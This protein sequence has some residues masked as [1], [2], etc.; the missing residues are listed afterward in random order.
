[1][2]LEGPRLNKQLFVGSLSECFSWIEKYLQH[3]NFIKVNEQD[4][5]PGMF[6][7]NTKH[8]IITLSL[9]VEAEKTFKFLHSIKMDYDAVEEFT[10]ARLNSLKG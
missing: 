6:S 2:S 9:M 3:E 4:P 8:G 7:W 10:E 1:M 5:Y